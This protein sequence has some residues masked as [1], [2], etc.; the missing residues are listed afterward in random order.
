MS[1]RVTKVLPD[2]LTYGT[3]VAFSLAILLPIL[4]VIRTSFATD[5][6]AYEIPPRLIFR[7][8]LDNYVELF[9]VSHFGAY[10]KNST[11]IALLATLVAT[12]IAFLGGYAFARYGV[13]GRLL[14]FAVLGTQ[15]LPGI[16][17]IL[18]IFTI[19]TRPERIESYPDYNEEVKARPTGVGDM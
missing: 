19:Y 1:P 5:V 16:V 13:G 9:R 18:P 12:P 7:P 15:M 8:T 11:V 17:L 2:L 10:L 4:W 6:I 14:Q 3:L